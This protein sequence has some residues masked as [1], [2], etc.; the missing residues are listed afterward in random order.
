M[1][2][3]TCIIWS[4]MYVSFLGHHPLLCLF[5]IHYITLYLPQ[6]SNMSSR[7]STSSET[8]GVSSSLANNRW[9]LGVWLFRTR[10]NGLSY[11][12][13]SIPLRD[14]KNLWR[15]LGNFSLMKAIQKQLVLSNETMGHPCN[16]HPRGSQATWIMPTAKVTSA[17]ITEA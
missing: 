14:A 11:L 1:L 8:P 13:F 16:L 12:A 2:H 7:A 10:E 4:S 9:H 3:S 5:Q 15:M 6:F 17:L